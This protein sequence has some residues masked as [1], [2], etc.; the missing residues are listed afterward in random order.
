MRVGEDTD[1]DSDLEVRTIPSASEGLKKV[2]EKL[3]ELEEIFSTTSDDM[4]W[5]VIKKNRYQNLDKMFL[6]S[7]FLH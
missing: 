6:A 2:K 3:T 5:E 4:E 1:S 7:F